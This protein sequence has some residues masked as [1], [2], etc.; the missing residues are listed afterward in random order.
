M[1]VSVCLGFL[2]VTQSPYTSFTAC[3]EP[4]TMHYADFA[5]APSRRNEMWAFKG[6]PRWNCQLAEAETFLQLHDCDYG[7]RFFR[8]VCRV[9]TR[10]MQVSLIDSVLVPI[11]ALLPS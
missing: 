4:R 5:C 2:L 3:L 1:S 10:H 11:F 9:S 8:H 6:L 7:G